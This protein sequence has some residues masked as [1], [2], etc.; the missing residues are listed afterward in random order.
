MGLREQIKNAGSEAEITQLI[1]K[2]KT[3]EFASDRTKNSWK[4][5]AKYRIAEL[6][7]Q[8]PAQTAPSDAT[9]PKKVSK[10]TVKNK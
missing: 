1:S 7:N 9:H 10:K 3:Y 4:S 6:S 5:T 8:I 2:G